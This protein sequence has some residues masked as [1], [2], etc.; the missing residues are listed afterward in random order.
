M[1]RTASP[2]PHASAARHECLEGREA[3]KSQGSTWPE[4]APPTTPNPVR[5]EKSHVRIWS[6][7]GRVALNVTHS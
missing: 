6:I 3:I 5:V 7:V 4:T 2:N 1:R